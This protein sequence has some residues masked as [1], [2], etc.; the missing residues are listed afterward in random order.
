MEQQ[1][2][3][4]HFSW[5]DGMP[6]G[7][8]VAILQKAYPSLSPGDRIDYETVSELLG[9]KVGSQRFI[10]VTLAWRA[11]EEDNNGIVILCKRK[12]AFIVATPDQITSGT[13]ETLRHIGRSARKQ[14]KHLATVHADDEMTRLTV[15]HQAR[16]MME[17]ERDAKKKRMNALPST[18]SAQIS[19]PLPTMAEA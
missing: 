18:Q 10:T 6:T 15:D 12:E 17:V 11:R 2:Q 14:R 9:V 3:Q 16:L 19:R 13:Y 1:N 8:D 4:K 5:R 7:P